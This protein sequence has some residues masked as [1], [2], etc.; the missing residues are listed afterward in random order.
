VPQDIN[1]D[2]SAKST[3][4][5]GVSPKVDKPLNP[6]DENTA[7]DSPK[8]SSPKGTQGSPGVGGA[9]TSPTRTA[10]VSSPFRY[11]GFSQIKQGLVFVGH[12]AH[13]L[14]LELPKL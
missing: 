9:L 11:S 5:G 6:H 12:A 4:V 13:G 10:R 1:Q 14:T 8:P 7:L 3:L 2:S